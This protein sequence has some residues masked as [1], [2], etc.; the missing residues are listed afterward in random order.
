MDQKYLILTSEHQRLNL[1]IMNM[2]R[3]NKELADN[4][5][6]LATQHAESSGEYEQELLK[7]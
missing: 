6:I 3:E 5:S 2:K 4:Q 7:K 1:E